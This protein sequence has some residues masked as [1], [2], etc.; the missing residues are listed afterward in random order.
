[1]STLTE[2]KGKDLQDAVEAMPKMYG[3]R[4][5]T[6]TETMVF[7]HSEYATLKST[8]KLAASV[9]F[10][11]SDAD[12]AIQKLEDMNVEFA[13]TNPDACNDYII[14]KDGRTV[15]HVVLL[16]GEPYHIK[17]WIADWNMLTLSD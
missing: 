14:L 4:L 2:L 1:M 7:C 15:Y 10:D 8:I 12:E 11:M 17:Q 5:V 16:D 6:P 9:G 3:I 13:S